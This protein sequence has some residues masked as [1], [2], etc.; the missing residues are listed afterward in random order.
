MTASKP[1]FAMST[2]R[3]G[4]SHID[5]VGPLLRQFFFSSVSLGRVGENPLSLHFPRPLC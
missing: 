1:F 5:I 3:V 2:Y 4:L